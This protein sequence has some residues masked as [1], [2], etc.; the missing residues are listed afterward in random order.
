MAVMIPLTH[1]HTPL[2]GGGGCWPDV[3]RP[4]LIKYYVRWRRWRG[5]GSGLMG[6]G[7][8]LSRV[9][10]NHV[11]P[12]ALCDRKEGDVRQVYKLCHIFVRGVGALK[13]PKQQNV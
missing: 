8:R 5:S 2:V 9:R 13:C 11:I 4:Y 3:T 6:S 7:V 10:V 1:L 12:V